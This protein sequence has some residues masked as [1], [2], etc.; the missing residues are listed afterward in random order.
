[1]AQIDKRQPPVA[2]ASDPADREAL[3]SFLRPRS[4]AQRRTSASHKALVELV[5]STL[6]SAGLDLDEFDSLRARGRT[7]LREWAEKGRAETDDHAKTLQPLI[8]HMA[9]SWRAQVQELQNFA[10]PPA[11]PFSYHLLDTASRISSSAGVT[12]SGTNTAPTNNWAEFQLFTEDSGSQQVTFTFSWQNQT[13][14]YVVI[15]VDGYLVLNGVVESSADPGFAAFFPGGTS[16]VWVD[17]QLYLSGLPWQTPD[18]PPQLVASG[19]PGLYLTAHAGWDDP[20]EIVSHPLFRGYDLQYQT[21]VVAPGGTVGVGVACGLSY[22]ND[23]GAASF[24]FTKLGRQVLC[25][26]VL[27][28]V[29]S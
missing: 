24:I 21:I 26:G 6:V 16:Q 20:G 13:E 3:A 28:T 19:T 23:D 15:N 25:P 2:A 22:I 14:K 9:E 12:L 18:T 10:P 27:I 4:S 1:V 11:S 8:A 7:E 5:T 17:G 29:V